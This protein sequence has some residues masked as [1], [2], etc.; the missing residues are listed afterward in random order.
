MGY[1][2]PMNKPKIELLEIDLLIPYARNS[3]T[4]SA[5]QVAQI[6]ASIKEFGFTSPVLIDA[7]GG[8]IAGH[9]RVMAARKLGMEQVP[10]IKLC[11]MTETQKRAYVIADNK[12]AL[13]GGWDNDL[14]ASELALLGKE[15]FNLELTGFDGDEINKI[16]DET[17]GITIQDEVIVIDDISSITVKIPSDKLTDAINIVSVAVSHIDGAV[18]WVGDEQV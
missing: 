12:L 10:C 14:L 13:N 5:E 18:I 7:A 4:H 9:G 3:R 11:H 8:I 2:V 15:K 1:D 6:A 16:F 17:G